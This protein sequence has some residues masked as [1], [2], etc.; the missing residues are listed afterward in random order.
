MCQNVATR[1]ENTQAHK[2]YFLV[3]SHSFS[4]FNDTR[5]SLSNFALAAKVTWLDDYWGSVWPDKEPGCHS[6]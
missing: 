1:L 2:V 5:I 3:S 6:T 4:N